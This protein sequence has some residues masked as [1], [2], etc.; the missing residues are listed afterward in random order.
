MIE[1]AAKIDQAPELRELQHEPDA[2]SVR[3]VTLSGLALVT[4]IALG[5]GISAVAIRQLSS[6]WSQVSADSQ[7]NQQETNPGVVSHQA[8]DRLQIQASEKKLLEQYR[9][10]DRAQGTASIPIDRAIELMSQRK[11]QTNWPVSDEVSP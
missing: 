4:I 6:R 9:W 7:W 1:P 2:T 10:H 11:L 5:I 8:Y 3:G